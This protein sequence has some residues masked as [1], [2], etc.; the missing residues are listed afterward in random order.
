MIKLKSIYNFLFSP[1]LNTGALLDTRPDELKEKDYKFEETV[2]AVNTVVW[3]EKPREKW[4]KFPEQDQ[5]Q[6]FSCV[7]QTI[8]KMLGVHYFLKTGKYVDFSST[9][10]YKRRSNSPWPGMAG[11]DALEIVRNK[12]VTLE[13]LVQSNQYKDKEI[14]SLE[15]EQY[16]QDVGDVF[17]IGNYLTITNVGDIETIA[18]I[19]QT[20]SKAVMIWFYFEK[21]EWSQFVPTIFNKNLTVGTMGVLRHSV[22]AVDFTLYNG[23]KSLVVE[24]S[25]HF[26]GLSTRVVNEDFFKARNYFAAYIIGFKFDSQL[27]DIYVPEQLPDDPN[28]PRYDFN[29]DL[30]FSPIYYTDADVVALQNILKYEGLFPTNIASSGYFGSITVKFVL[31]WQKLHK[32]CSDAELELLDGKIVGPQTRAKLNVLYGT[33]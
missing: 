29:K 11:V 20:T 15:I 18:S 4:R 23:K 30:R 12:G 21:E 24:D 32:V 33:K 2:A 5:R 31:A 19:I 17:K 14:D 7:S 1:K 3:A 10:I 25:A 16:K 26:G 27:P 28:R 13:Q 8:R 6:T 9:H 22:T